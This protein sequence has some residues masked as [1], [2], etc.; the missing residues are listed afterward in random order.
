MRKYYLPS[1]LKDVCNQE[2]YERW[3]RRAAKR[4]I[5]RDRKRGNV[6][7]SP[8]SYREAIHNAVRTKGEFDS[9][10]GERLDWSL[11]STYNNAESK[12]K[13]RKYKALFALL[14]SVDHV[15]DGTSAANF[16]LCGWRTNDAKNDLT[17]SEFLELCQR[18]C[19]FASAANSH[20]DIR[21]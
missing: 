19:K 17:Y 9:Y 12:A 18:V 4:H 8:K 7:D 2:K 11:I 20:S 3:L 5:K 16:R 14:P 1:F 13:R 6:L 10:T 15:G 21:S